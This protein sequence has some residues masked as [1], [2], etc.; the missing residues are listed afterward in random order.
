MRKVITA[1]DI[2]KTACGPLNPHL[3]EKPVRKQKKSKYGNSKTEVD[4]IKFDSIREAKRYGELK[5][6]QKAG[7]IGQLRLQVE[8]E[9]NPGGT[10]SLKY[11][12][13]FVYILSKTGETVVEDGKGALTQVYRKKRRLMLK[14]HEIKIKEV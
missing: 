7:I 12:A 11:L 8:Y 10:H 9:L 3:A 4:G 6:M 5:I 14:V 1:E 2:L 13:D